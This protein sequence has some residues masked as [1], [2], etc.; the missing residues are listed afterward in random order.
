MLFDGYFGDPEATAAVMSD[1]WFR[2]GDLAEVDAEGY[3]S[4]VGRARDLIRTGGESVAPLE[5]EQALAGHP[6]V[7]DLAVV[8]MPDVEW[9][10]VVCAVVVL[11]D[12]AVPPSVDELRDRCRGSLAAYKHPRRV[13]VV[14]AIPRS[15]SN[16]K[17]RRT[18]LVAQLSSRSVAA[19]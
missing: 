4:I 1:G 15:E 16:G 13:E 8:G 2:T 17:T 5:V 10:E 3:L 11:R 18:L 6:A 12:G 19:R 7:A 9:G 14:E